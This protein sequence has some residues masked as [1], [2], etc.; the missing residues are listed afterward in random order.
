MNEEKLEE[1][2][3]SMRAHGF[4]PAHSLLVRPANEVRV[5]EEE[6]AIRVNSS[7]PHSKP[8]T[9]DFAVPSLCANT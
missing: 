5:R 7:S 6:G 1:L 2:V 8:R 4:K 3:E 9:R